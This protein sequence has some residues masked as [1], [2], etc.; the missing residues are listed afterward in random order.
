MQPRTLRCHSLSFHPGTHHSTGSLSS[1]FV[2]FG[3]EPLGRLSRLTGA[4][5]S[6]TR[7][8]V[9]CRT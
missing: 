1:G 8:G 7:G 2:S 4:I 3:T 9:I 6:D 5:T